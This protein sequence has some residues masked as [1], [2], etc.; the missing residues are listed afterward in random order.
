LLK[1]YVD[2]GYLGRKAG[3]GFYMYTEQGVAIPPVAR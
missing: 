2:A 3:R 1:K